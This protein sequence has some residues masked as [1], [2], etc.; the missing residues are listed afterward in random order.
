M[1]YDSALVDFRER[2]QKPQRSV[3]RQ[4]RRNQRQR[5]LQ[6]FQ[7]PNVKNAQKLQMTTLMKRRLVVPRL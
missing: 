5:P 6:L 7:A 2:K 3:E 1:N 4:Q